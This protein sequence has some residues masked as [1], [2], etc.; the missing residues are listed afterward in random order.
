MVVHSV[1]HK[2]VCMFQG[3]SS[4]N[5]DIRSLNASDK[6]ATRMQDS[7]CSRTINSDHYIANTNLFCCCLNQPEV[8]KTKARQLL[9]WPSAILPLNYLLI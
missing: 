8:L 5:I 3:S 4:E 2:N 9:G 7:Y 1:L 6:T